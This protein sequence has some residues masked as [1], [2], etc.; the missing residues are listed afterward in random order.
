MSKYTF[1]VP[2]YKSSFLREALR[3]IKQ[4]T[5]IDFKVIVS[6]D[7]SPEDLRSIYNREVG[8]DSRFEFRS[9]EKN[10]GSYSLVSHWNLLIELCKTDYLIMASDDDVY[11]PFFLDEINTQI[12]RHPDAYLYRSFVNRINEQGDIIE[13]ES[14]I[15]GYETPLS[16]MASHFKPGRVHCIGNYVFNKDYLLSVGGFVDFPLAW[17]S[18]D[19]TILLCSK[20]GV[21]NTASAAFSFR[22]SDVNISN[23]RNVDQKVAVNK[24]K[25]TKLFYNWS[26]AFLKGINKPRDSQEDECYSF[27]SKK[28]NER[29]GWQLRYYYYFLPVMQKIRLLMWMIGNGFKN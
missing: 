15:E 1:L 21:C 4:Q 14:P 20:N 22:D 11:A 24:I 7:C 8:D 10:I 5:Y 18:D 29:I 3:S 2:S 25:A 13:R 16:A 26:S 28:M 12:E 17:F 23:D 27:L 9:N 19:A 6:D